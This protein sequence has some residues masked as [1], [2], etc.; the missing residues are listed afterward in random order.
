MQHQQYQVHCDCNQ[1]HLT[2][3]GDPRVRAYCHCGDCRSLLNVPYHS[4]AAWEGDNVTITQGSELTREFQHPHLTMTRVFC[5]HCGEM[6]YNTN[7]MGWKLVSQLL[8]RKNYNNEVPE[9]LLPTQ[10][11]FYDRRIIDIA[12]D[13]PKNPPQ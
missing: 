5:T 1:V 8:L 13:L 10:H 3:K 4:I 11:F 9:E 6:L 7:K 12:D 2:M